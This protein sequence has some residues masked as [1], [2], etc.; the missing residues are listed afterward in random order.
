MT[1]AEQKAREA[2]KWIIEVSP[3]LLFDD[4]VVAILAAR[5]DAIEECAKV[6][7]GLV[8]RFARQDGT[9]AERMR[10]AIAAAIRALAKEEPPNED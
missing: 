9:R 8:V 6:A 3:G 2:A 5:R 1:P 4:I 10:E 7:D